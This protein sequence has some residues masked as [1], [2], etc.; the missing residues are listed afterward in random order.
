MGRGQSCRTREGAGV[1]LLYIFPRLSAWEL[2]PSEAFGCD[3]F[4]P[5]ATPSFVD[6]PSPFTPPLVP[7]PRVGLC[8]S[9]RPK[10]GRKGTGP[11]RFPTMGTLTEMPPPDP[12]PADCPWG[13]F[14]FDA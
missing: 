8:L 2:V 3:P 14:G 12:P 6:E 4:E 11:I 7:S 5:V 13:G 10:S 1:G 9:C